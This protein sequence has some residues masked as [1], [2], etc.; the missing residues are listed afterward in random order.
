MSEGK[1]GI[2]E[3]ML[4]LYS[5]FPVTT[6]LRY[7]RNVARGI[8]S[9][10]REKRADM[11][12][13][14]WHGSNRDR[15]FRLG[16]TV[17]PVIARSPCDV[18]VMKDCGNKKFTNVLV[19]ILGSVNDSLA[20]ET[21]GMLVEKTTGH[22]TTLFEKSGKHGDRIQRAVSRL[23]DRT[24][25][26]RSQVKTQNAAVS[27]LVRAVVRRADQYDLVVMGL[28]DPIRRR[29]GVSSTSEIIARRCSIPLVL[30][31]AATGLEAIT[32]RI[33]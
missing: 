24:E 9:A 17:D 12:I 15:R 5:R 26:N 30:V 25:L 32:K 4:Y 29:L 2:V 14:G 31:K 19:P 8:V 18:I 3:A 10:V 27:D 28:K 23:V 13:M 21:A 22:M 1:E 16:S 7:C 20:L 33:I 6:T 11:V